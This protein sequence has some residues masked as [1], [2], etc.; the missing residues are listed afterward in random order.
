MNSCDVLSLGGH[1]NTATPLGLDMAGGRACVRSGTG[2]LAVQRR[3]QLASEMNVGGRKRG[4]SGRSVFGG[5]AGGG[6]SWEGEKG[7]GRI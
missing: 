6:G 3:P 4:L 5:G 7:R 2:A 1:D